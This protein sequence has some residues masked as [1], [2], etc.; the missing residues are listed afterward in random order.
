[1]AAN[2]SGK[3]QTPNREELLQMA[4]RTAKQG[5]AEAARNMFGRILTEDKRNER[6]LMWMAKLSDSKAERRQW[7]EKV[8]DINPTNEIARDALRK[9]E[10]KS[11][12]SDIRTLLI[13]GMLA[14]IMIVLA[15][16][17]ILALFVLP[18]MSA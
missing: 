18:G 17:L 4:I 7:L 1:M 6:A 12:A 13:F 5:N 3:N 2:S 10:Y 11:T 8:I 9:M 15:V 14:G 16:V